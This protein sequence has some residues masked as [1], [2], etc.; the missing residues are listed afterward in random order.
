MEIL[1][2]AQSIGSSERA[3]RA[4]LDLNLKDANLSFSEW[5][6][7]LYIDASPLDIE[8]VTQMLISARIVS[9]ADETRRAVDKLISTGL[10]VADKDGALAHSD[11]GAAIFRDLST[12][13][14]GINQGLYGDLPDRDLAATHRTLLLITI[15]ANDAISIYE[16]LK[17]APQTID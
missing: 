7:L 5:V 13:F 17:I 11:E 6:T 16:R 8:Q 10:I 3:V 15:R 14:I 4:L 2:L 12:K 9:G 1:S